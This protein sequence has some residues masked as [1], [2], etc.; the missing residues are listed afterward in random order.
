ML[1]DILLIFVCLFAALGIVELAVY[2]FNSACAR[3]MKCKFYIL[4]DDFDESE[5]EYAIRFL[6]N[7]IAHSGIDCLVCGIK[8]GENAKISPEL[9]HSLN[10]EYR[11]IIT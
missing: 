1:Y 5:A 10:I 4:A 3:K 11:N 8:L 6:E 7:L 9:L 2:I